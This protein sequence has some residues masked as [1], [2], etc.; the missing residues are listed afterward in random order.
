MKLS[1]KIEL[2]F[3]YHRIIRWLQ[4][5]RWTKRTQFWLFPNYTPQTSLFCRFS[6]EK[7][8]RKIA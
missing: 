4:R 6:T 8:K 7:G 5:F 3:R 1:P 2:G